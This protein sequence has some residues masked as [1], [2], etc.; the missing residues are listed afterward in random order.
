MTKYYMYAKLLLLKPGQ[1][2]STLH[3][4]NR[5]EFSYSP[6]LISAFGHGISCNKDRTVMVVWKKSGR[7]EMSIF[8]QPSIIKSSSFFVGAFKGDVEA[9]HVESNRSHATWNLTVGVPEINQYLISAVNETARFYDSRIFPPSTTKSLFF[10]ALAKDSAIMMVMVSYRSCKHLYMDITAGVSLIRVKVLH[11]RLFVEYWDLIYDFPMKKMYTR[12]QTI[13]Y[14]TGTSCTS[15]RYMLTRFLQSESN[16]LGKVFW[17]GRLEPVGYLLDSCAPKNS[18]F[19]D[20]NE[21]PRLTDCFLNTVLVWVPCAFLWCPL[22]FYLVVLARK[23]EVTPL[24]VTW[25]NSAKTCFSM[26]LSMVA[27]VSLIQDFKLLTD[28]GSD[29]LPVVIYLAS[30][31]RL[32]TYMCTAFLTQHERRRHVI[33][34]DLQFVFW[35]LLTLCDVVP[36]YTAIIEESILSNES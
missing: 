24:H 8:M 12:N 23:G 17:V 36:F 1:P 16:P 29:V 3:P 4:E 34:S 19:Y 15:D 2:L 6:E 14:A 5:K 25:L 28:S 11:S 35:T 9:I 26:V 10:P 30:A 32:V 27:L 18:S 20:L 31:L 21:F 22:P 33:T 13:N 7:R